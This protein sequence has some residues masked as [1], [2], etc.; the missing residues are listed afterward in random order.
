MQAHKQTP[1]STAINPSKVWEQFVADIYSIRKRTQLGKF[2]YHINN[3]HQ[4]IKLTID[5][6]SME[7]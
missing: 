6:E 2:F 7:N 5:E 4:N 1:I 3:F